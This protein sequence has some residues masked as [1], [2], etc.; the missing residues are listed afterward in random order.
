MLPC[1][2]LGKRLDQFA[3]A[4]AVALGIPREEALAMAVLVHLVTVIPVALSG[5]AALLLTGAN[6]STIAAQA[7]EAEAAHPEPA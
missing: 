7:E 5:A 3:T 6:L 1:G 4:T 2:D